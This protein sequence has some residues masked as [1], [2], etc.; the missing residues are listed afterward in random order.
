MTEAGSEFDR[1]LPALAT[2][3]N[4]LQMDM[5]VGFATSGGPPRG[6][7]SP[8]LHVKD[9]CNLRS[10]ESVCKPL[11]LPLTDNSEHQGIP[12][13]RMDAE[14]A[15]LLRDISIVHQPALSL[16]PPRIRTYVA[17]SWFARS[18][19]INRALDLTN[20]MKNFPVVI[21]SYYGH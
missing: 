19:E 7:N 10:S 3:W 9:L 1:G 15:L 20:P 4:T 5:R 16:T 13:I 2:H 8:A 14:P 6:A 17:A 18:I 12:L 11:A 21:R